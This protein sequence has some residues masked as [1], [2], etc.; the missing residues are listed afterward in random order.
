MIAILEIFQDEEGSVAV[1]M[2]LERCG[3]PFAS[4][5][6]AEPHAEAAVTLGG[7]RSRGRDRRRRN[8]LLAELV[9]R[10]SD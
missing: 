2:V 1:P 6:R 7:G 9:R 3:T 8:H 4:G 10:R 5:P